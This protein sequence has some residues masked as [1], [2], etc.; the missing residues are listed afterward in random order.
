MDCGLVKMIKIVIP[1]LTMML[2]MSCVSMDEGNEEV[3]YDAKEVINYLA[4]G[5]SYTIGQGVEE[6]QRW[7]NQLSEKLHE[8]NFEVD[9]LKIIAQPGWTTSNLIEGIEHVEMGT[10]DLVSLLIGVNNQY[11]N[12]PFTTFET[13]F[14]ILLN[15]S[16]EF[17]GDTKRVF[18][19]SIPDY[20]VTPFG[21]SYSE[22][23]RQEIDLYNE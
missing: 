4:L 11:Q 13:E 19:V 2:I 1:V 5:D 18:V 8:S 21:S 7:P 9:S 14:N 23:I 22:G 12:Q 3:I 15:K 20:G 6:K 10:Y 17:A 16:L